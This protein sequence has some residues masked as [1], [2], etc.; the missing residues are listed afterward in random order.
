VADFRRR[1]VD[2]LEFAGEDYRRQILT[3]FER[4][5]RVH[6][7]GLAIELA[8]CIP[9]STDTAGD[10]ER[11]NRRSS[12]GERT[13]LLSDSVQKPVLVGMAADPEPRDFILLKKP[14]CS[15][16]QGDADRVD[17]FTGVNLLEP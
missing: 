5:L 7:M 15:V 14:N 8:V 16:P 6:L 17:R 11:I 9:T 3:F 1:T 13:R 2:Y 10:K 4:T 12:R